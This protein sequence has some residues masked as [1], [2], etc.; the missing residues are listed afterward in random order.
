MLRKGGSKGGSRLSAP[1]SAPG[2]GLLLDLV[3]ESQ[4]EQWVELVRL[5]IKRTSWSL[6]LDGGEEVLPL[7]LK[8][9]C[10]EAQ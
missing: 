1:G 9:R 5:T 6:W 2:S 7:E 8:T 4:Q 3:P 10:R